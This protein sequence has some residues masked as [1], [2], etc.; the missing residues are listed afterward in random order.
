MKL[1]KYV[2]PYTVSYNGKTA[3]LRASA[4]SK[5][6]G[7]VNVAMADTSMKYIVDSVDLRVWQAMST[8]A[9]GEQVTIP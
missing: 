7:G 2:L 3:F 5:H 4:R 6:I 8:R 1:G 9:G